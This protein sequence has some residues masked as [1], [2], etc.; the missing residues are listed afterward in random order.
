MDEH[1]GEKIQRVTFSYSKS[2]EYKQFYVTGARGGVRPYDFRLDFYNE[3]PERLEI[4]KSDVKG[5]PI[6]RKHLGELKV[7]REYKTG[8]IL[9]YRALLEL[10]KFL[11]DQIEKMKEKGLI[12]EM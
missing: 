3:E 11:N 9:S 4:V 1:E 12:E 2:P 5:R 6:R 8:I 7:H 10:S